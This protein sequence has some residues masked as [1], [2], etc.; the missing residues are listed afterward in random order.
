MKI[1]QEIAERSITLVR[2]RPGLLPLR[3]GAGQKVAVIVPKPQDLTP[4]DT[5]SYVRP[6]LAEALREYHPNIIELSVPYAPADSDIG[7]ILP[8]LVGYD[9]IIVGTL[10]ASHQEGQAELVRQVLKT[11]IPSIV[12]AMRLPYD[13]AAFPEAPV[14]LCTY[15]LLEPS[16]RAA[17]GAI[18]GRMEMQ[19]RLPV[20]IPGLHA[21]G[22]SFKR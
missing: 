14:Y 13:L 2:D 21:A 9:L 10:N 17:A 5:S 15:G 6:Y 18:F 1:A 12:I 16:M 22:Y 3:L 4:A 20:T 8:A 19:G 7:L 11:A